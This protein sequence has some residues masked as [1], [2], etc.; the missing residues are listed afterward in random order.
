ML[1]FHED[2]H[3]IHGIGRAIFL[4]VV[5]EGLSQSN[6]GNAA[7]VKDIV[8]HVGLFKPETYNATQR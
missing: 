8:A 2:V 4:D 1:F 3:L 5:G 6:E 7:L